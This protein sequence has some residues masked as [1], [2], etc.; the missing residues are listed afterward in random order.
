MRNMN[1]THATLMIQNQDEGQT[2]SP[3]HRSKST[4][5]ITEPDNH[6]PPGSFRGR[7]PSFRQ[8]KKGVK[9]SSKSR[10]SKGQKDSPAEGL[11][12]I[13]PV[14]YVSQTS[15]S[16]FAQDDHE[17]DSRSSTY[18]HYRVDQSRL[19]GRTSHSPLLVEAEIITKE[20]SR[21][22][23]KRSSSRKK[24]NSEGH[25]EAEVADSTKNDHTEAAA[26][27]TEK[28]PELIDM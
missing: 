15:S 22:S 1:S 24:G 9:S 6:A 27:T 16:N 7:D 25:A 26:N 18:S 2:T 8:S 12:Q 28:P 5:S 19:E 14:S 11:E 17:H 10:K 4:A 21:K 13:D 23:H 20:I 3:R